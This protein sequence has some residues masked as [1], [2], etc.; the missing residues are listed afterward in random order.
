MIFSSINYYLFNFS[1]I[2]EKNKTAKK[3]NPQYDSLYRGR[4]EKDLNE[5]APH[6]FTYQEG[7]VFASWLIGNGWANAWGVFLY[8]NATFSEVY[9]HFRRFLVVK[10]EEGQELYFRFYDPRVL[11]VFLPTCDAA[12]LKEFFGPVSYF[13]MED[14]DPSFGLQFS[15]IQGQLQ[16]N[17]IARQNFN[18][19]SVT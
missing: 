16:T 14:E 10:N 9:K 17:R 5:V 8:A 3:L 1:Q 18:A 11:R 6:L 4:S 2:S 19:T 15:L 7:T 13:F 12:Q